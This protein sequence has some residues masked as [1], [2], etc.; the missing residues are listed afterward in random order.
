[1]PLDPSVNAKIDALISD[2][3]AAEQD[4][5][6]ASDSN[7]AAQAAAQ[8]AVASAAGT[9]QSK[10]TAHDGLS[11]SIDALVEFVTSLK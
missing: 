1:M 8:A 9:A 11:A 6:D 10:A 7:D 5:S 2:L 3:R 4:F